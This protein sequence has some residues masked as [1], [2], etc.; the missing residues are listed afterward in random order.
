[1]FQ[2]KKKKMH[3]PVCKTKYTLFN[4]LITVKITKCNARYA[5]ESKIKKN[6]T[7]D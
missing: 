4:Y 1:M 3:V 7:R 2:K 6:K 5:R